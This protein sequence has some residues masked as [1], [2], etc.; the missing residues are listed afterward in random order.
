MALWTDIITPAELTGNARESAVLLAR[1]A[2][3]DGA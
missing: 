1:A 2:A 3:C